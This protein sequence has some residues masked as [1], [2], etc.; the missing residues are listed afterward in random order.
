MKVETMERVFKYMGKTL[1][2]PNPNL[3]P[4][5]LQ[6]VFSLQ[7][8]EIASAHYDREIVGNKEIITYQQA[9]GKKG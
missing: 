5:A 2:D 9:L 3:T 6:S 8:P 1:K 7:Y 4:E